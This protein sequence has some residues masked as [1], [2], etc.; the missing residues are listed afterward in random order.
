MLGSRWVGGELEFCCWGA[1][2]DGA[3]VSFVGVHVCGRL[4][5][6]FIV[7]EVGVGVGDVVFAVEGIVVG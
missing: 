2:G 7:V 1:R 6:V 5:V 4:D 3:V